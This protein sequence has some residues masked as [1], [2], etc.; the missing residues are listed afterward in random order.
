[1]GA[2]TIA[3]MAPC[4]LSFVLFFS[5]SVCVCVCVFLCVCVPARIQT[6]RLVETPLG[7]E[8]CVCARVRVCVCVLLCD[9][10]ACDVCVWRCVMVCLGGLNLRVLPLH[11]L[12]PLLTT[13]PAHTH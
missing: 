9:V 8:G 5:L 10:C 7:G 13:H 2:F 12:T 6:S 4:S 11:E 3:L 1:M